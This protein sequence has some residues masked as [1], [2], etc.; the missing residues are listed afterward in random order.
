MLVPTLTSTIPLCTTTRQPDSNGYVPPGTCGYH[1]KMYY[2]SFAIAVLFTVIAAAILTGHLVQ[3]FRYPKDGPQKFLS[4]I[5]ACI[6]SGYVA[7]TV[8]TRHQQNIPIAAFSDTMI[9]ICP[10]RKFSD[11]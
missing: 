6:F 9:L 10:T 11:H 7:R 5:S 2:P 4:F 3:T 8:G 1:G